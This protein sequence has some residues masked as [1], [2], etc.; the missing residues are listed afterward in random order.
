MRDCRQAW[1]HEMGFSRMDASRR[2]SV[3]RKAGRRR[4]DL[5][6]HHVSSV[7]LNPGLC[8]KVRVVKFE[9]A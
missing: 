9:P 4:L 7:N 3:A 1:F 8:A 6:R 2:P 5:D